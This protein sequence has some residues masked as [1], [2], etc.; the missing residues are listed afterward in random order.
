MGKKIT[1][2]ETEVPSGKEMNDKDYL[3]AVLTIEKNITNNISIALNEASNEELYKE[4]FAFFK[5]TQDLQRELFELAF[6]NGWYTLEEADKSKIKE[7]HTEIN[8]QLSE[9]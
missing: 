5:E 8:N 1:N 2:P 6:K 3:N 7:K 4:F 9:L